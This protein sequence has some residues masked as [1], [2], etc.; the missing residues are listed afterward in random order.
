MSGTSTEADGTVITVYKGGVSQGTTTVSSGVWTKSGLTL[1]NG[2]VITATAMASG[3]CVSS[4]SSPVSVNATPNAPTGSPTQSFCESISPTVTNLVAS[5]SNIHWYDEGG[6]PLSLGTALTTES[7]YYAS[8]TVNGCES[9]GRLEVA[10]TVYSIPTLSIGTNPSVCKGTTSYSLSVA[11]SGD[12]QKYSIDYNTAANSAGFIDVNNVSF[13]NPLMLNIPVGA[14]AGTYSGTITL[15]NGPG[16]TGCSSSNYSFTVTINDA[17]TI[18]LTSGT[19]YV[20]SGSTSGNLPYTSISGSPTLYSID[21]NAAA[22][23][24]GFIDVT[25]VTLPSSPIVFSVPSGVA[26]G[27]YIA[28]LRVKNYLGCIS[29]SYPVSIIISSNIQWTGAV[30]T[31]WSVAGNWSSNYVPTSLDNAEISSGVTNMPHITTAL[32]SPTV[33]NNLVINGGAVVTVDAGKALTVNGNLIVNGAE[34]LIVKASSSLNG[35][36]ITLGN[37]TYLNSGSVRVEKYV[38]GGSTSHWEYLSSPITSASS[39]VFTSSTRK[40]NRVNE[41]TN[42]WITIA[43]TPTENLIV[44]NGYARN[45]YTADGDANTTKN[46]VGSVNTGAQSI[47][48]T[49]TESAPGSKHGWN[50]VGNPYPDAIDWNASSGWTKANLNNAIYYRFDGNI[51]AYVDGV[52]TGSTATS[53]IIPPM[54]SFWV[55]VDS[56]QSSATLACNNSVR[57]HNTTAAAVTPVNTL[58]LTVVNNS[59]PLS[60]DTYLRFKNYASD[61]FDGQYDAYKMYASDATIPQIYTRIPTADDISINTM[62]ALSGA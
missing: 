29:T 9:M 52:G 62:G 36:L 15:K 16:G 10:V 1:A 47:S 21:F 51:K 38:S 33:C 11:T 45:Y 57:V 22:N 37:I 5:G 23:T 46:L 12:P 61:G 60:D 40:L 49:R 3:Y 44:L 50:L 20:L 8:Q 26:N 56:L 2:N 48:L 42:A 7:L 41:P 30:S 24:A 55:R 18:T 27:T 54:T 14:S 17:P 58:H 59:S 43:N 34:A 31:D 4:P 35:S 19:V 13:T 28:A 6:S 32:T 39:G 25:D 53:G